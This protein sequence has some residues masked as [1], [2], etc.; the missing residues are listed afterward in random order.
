MAIIF[1]SP[2]RRQRIVLM[3]MLGLLAVAFLAIGTLAF[4]PEIE[5]A[6][7][8]AN[9]AQVSAPIPDIKINFGVVDS[10]KVKNL[11]LFTGIPDQSSAVGRINP[12][13]SYYQVTSKPK[14]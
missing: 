4:L 6:L 14:K 13:T 12:F 11:D 10:P 2:K 3:S 8:Y 5:Q 9:T 1:V 7:H